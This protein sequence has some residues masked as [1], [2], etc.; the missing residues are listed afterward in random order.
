MRAQDTAKPKRDGK[1]EE[2]KGRREGARE[3]EKEQ[4]TGKARRGKLR[5]TDR[6]VKVSPGVRGRATWRGEN[7]EPARLERE[8][9]PQKRG[10]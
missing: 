4:G 3:R 8:R 5:D 10:G 1:E 7:V 6:D 2:E 9:D